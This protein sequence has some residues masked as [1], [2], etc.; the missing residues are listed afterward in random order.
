MELQDYR[1]NRWEAGGK[2]NH[3]LFGDPKGRMNYRDYRDNRQK[4][5][6][7]IVTFTRAAA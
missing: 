5:K 7:D 4:P 2:G 1:D 6:E 3:M